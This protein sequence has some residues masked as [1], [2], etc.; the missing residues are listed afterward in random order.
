[1]KF[2]L[3]QDVYASTARLLKRQSL[4]QHFIVV[5]PGGHRVRKKFLAAREYA[6]VERR[7]CPRAKLT[8]SVR[9][10][11]SRGVARSPVLH[12]DTLCPAGAIGSSDIVVLGESET[13]SD[14]DLLPNFNLPVRE[15]FEG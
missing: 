13:L 1:M 4:R 5:E 14:A 7:R 12:R 9:L 15:V 6:L 8:A 11:P 10:L 2:L 3:D